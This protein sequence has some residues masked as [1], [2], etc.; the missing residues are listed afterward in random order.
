MNIRRRMWIVV[1]ILAT[2]LVLAVSCSRDREKDATP[3]IETQGDSLE[4]APGA[5]DGEFAYWTCTMHPSVRESH[6][7]KCPICGMDLVPVKK[8]ASPD[9]TGTD[10]SFSVSAEKQRLAGVT[11]ATVERKPIDKVIRAYGRVTYDETRLAVVNLRVSGWIEKLFVDF[12]GQPVGKGAPLF[13]LY[14]PD[15]VSAQ[16]EYLLARKTAM[17]TGSLSK[18]EDLVRTARERLRLWQLSDEQIRQLEERGTPETRVVIGSPASGFVVEKMALE[19]MRVE[20]GMTL[21]K[22][23]D[24]STVWVQAEIYEYDLP[25][26]HVG[27]HATISF[28]GPDRSVI[29]GK[30]AYIDPVLQAETRAARV[31]I[32]LANPKG[33]LKPDMYADVALHADLG[34]RLVI[35]ETA[36]LRTGE[37]QIVFVNRGD[38]AFELRFVKLGVRGEGEYEVSDGLEEGEHVVSSANFLIDAE[39]NVQ[40]VLR[41]LEGE[42]SAPA[43]GHVH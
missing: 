4:T 13:S 2:G 35:P 10:L 19:G 16:S 18:D 12:T 5:E 17:S 8:S 23:A 20:P 31:R 27:Q 29:E 3:G 1:I 40:G 24:L 25:L 7:G 30:V 39:S 11:F 37:R 36:V 28:A 21:Y 38:G 41:R 6:P 15:L 14:S 34:A 32:E 33:R 26:V 42:T 22:I 43:P 9:T